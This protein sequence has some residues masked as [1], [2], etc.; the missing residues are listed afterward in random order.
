[1]CVCVSAGCHLSADLARYYGGC[2][3]ACFSGSC[4]KMTRLNQPNTNYCCASV[5][6]FS[7]RNILV[8]HVSSCK[9]KILVEVYLKFRALGSAMLACHCLKCLSRTLIITLINPMSKQ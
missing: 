7:E 6:L 9:C 2:V 3:N 8:C 4:L 5:L 1:M